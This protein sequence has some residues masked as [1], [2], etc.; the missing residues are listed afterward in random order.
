MEKIHVNM[1][2]HVFVLSCIF[3]TSKHKNMR[4]SMYFLQENDGD[5]AVV[6]TNVQSQEVPVGVV[7]SHDDGDLFLLLRS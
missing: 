4:V 6:P 2:L 7:P 5:E 1:V 3:L